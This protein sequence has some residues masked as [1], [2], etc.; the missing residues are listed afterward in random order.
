MIG[1][2]APDFL[3]GGIIAD[4]KA[5]PSDGRE[6]TH[7]YHYV[8]PM[9]DNPWRE[10]LRQHPSLAQPKSAAHRAFLMGYVAHLAADEFWSRYVLKPHFAESNWGQDRKERFFVLHLLLIYMD[11]RD[12]ARL[13]RDLPDL[14]RHCGPQA[15]LPFLPDHKICEWR[16]Y[17]ARQLE[18]HS[19]TLAIFGGRINTEPAALRALL[20]DADAMQSR[21]WDHVPLVTITQLETQMYAFAREQV[22]IYMQEYLS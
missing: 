11:E 14:M 5:K 8:R 20:D 12:E 18:G 9:P 19:E 21:L 6:L 4:Q 3:L 7:F 13:P 10:M 1:P 15:W 17:L 22:E 2:Y 16:D